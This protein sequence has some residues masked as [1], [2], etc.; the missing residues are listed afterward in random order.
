MF[1]PASAIKSQ[2]LADFVAEFSPAMLP[3]LRQE[4][5]L[6]SEKGETGEWTLY[7]DGSSNV[8]GAGV[9]I[10][11]TSHV[12]DAASRAVRC[13]FKATNNERKRSGPEN[14][15]FSFRMSRL[16]SICIKISSGLVGQS[17]MN[18]LSNAYPRNSTDR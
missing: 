11:L 13:N 12:G 3:T 2:V 18:Y 16:S 8:Q 14:V 7:V 4:I 5:K 1:W 6:Q 15:T 10:V 9:G 17:E